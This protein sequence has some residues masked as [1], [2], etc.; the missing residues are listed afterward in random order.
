MSRQDREEKQNE[1]NLSAK[2]KSESVSLLLWDSKLGD[3]QEGWC[4]QVRDN[5]QSGRGQ[6]AGAQDR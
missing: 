3:I 4:S 1:T 2:M 6:A 5:D